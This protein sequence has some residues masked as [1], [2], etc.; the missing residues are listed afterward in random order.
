MSAA[1]VLGS[2]VAGFYP[3]PSGAARSID[4]LLTRSRL[5]GRSISLLPVSVV[6]SP[7][8]R[9]PVSK[10]SYRCSFARVFLVRFGSA[11]ERARATW[12]QLSQT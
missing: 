12:H 10:T 9:P 3:A 6:P 1:R 4:R 5:P 2:M 11:R 7:L 8:L